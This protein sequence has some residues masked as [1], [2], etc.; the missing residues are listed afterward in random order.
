MMNANSHF[1]TLRYLLNTYTNLFAYG[2]HYSNKN[3]LN[4][5]LQWCGQR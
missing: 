1:G 5:Q 3:G 2:V 4:I